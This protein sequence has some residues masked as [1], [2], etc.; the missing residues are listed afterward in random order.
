MSFFVNAVDRFC[1]R[2]PRFGISRLMLYI[3]IGNAAVYFITV[4]D[5]NLTL[6]YLLSFNPSLIMQ[7][8]IWRLVSFVFLPKY[9]SISGFGLLQQ[10]LFLYFYYFIGS[11]LEREWGSGKFTI[12]YCFGVL[13]TLIYGFLACALTGYWGGLGISTSYINLAMFF[14]YAT[15]YPEHRVMVFFIIPVKMKWL[16]YLGAFFFLIAII[17]DP[18]PLNLLPVVG[19]LNYLL[20]FGSDLFHAAKNTVGNLSRRFSKRTIDFKSAAKQQEK[21]ARERG[22]RHKCSVCGRTDTDNPGLEFRY[23][24]RCAG[25]HCF[26]VD[27]INNHVHF[28]E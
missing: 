16:A 10:A 19:V 21:K 22:Y 27:H 23:C 13:L 1:A 5:S 14:A 12:Y 15:L 17:T 20:F 3:I 11:M 9:T 4:M 8:Q 7:G 26:C 24:S 28:T 6:Y 18:F 2:H 25:Y